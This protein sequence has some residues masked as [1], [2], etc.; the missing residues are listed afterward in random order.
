M[1]FFEKDQFLCGNDGF[2]LKEGR[3][4][5]VLFCENIMESEF[6]ILPKFSVMK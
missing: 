1:N 5:H 3:Q 2:W 4:E 6:L